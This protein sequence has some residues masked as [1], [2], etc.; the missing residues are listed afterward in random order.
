MPTDSTLGFGSILAY[1]SAGTTYTAI[2][3]TV[4]LSGPEPEIGD[5]KITNN[6]SPNRTHEYHPGGLIE[7]GE[8]DFQVVY[9]KSVCATL[10]AMF[11]DEINYFWRETYPD[12]SKWDFKG[13]LK[14]FGT[15]APTEDDK[16]TNTMTL[17][18]T[19]KPV[20]TAA[21]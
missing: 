4:D 20:F 3:Q 10:Y 2:A 15:E 19:N 12:G 16:M 5:V 17:K 7:P 8:M 18:L 13:Y 21:A 6:D 9:K 11:G 14:K 1:S